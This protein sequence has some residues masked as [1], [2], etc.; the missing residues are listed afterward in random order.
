MNEKTSPHEDYYHTLDT[1]LHRLYK[2]E[3]SL[4]LTMISH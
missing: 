2:G 3:L 1:F 4:F